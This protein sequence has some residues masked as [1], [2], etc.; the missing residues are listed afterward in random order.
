MELEIDA[1]QVLQQALAQ[2]KPGEDIDEAILRACKALYP[3][4][5][6]QA[7]TAVSRMVGAMAQQQGL[8]KDEAIQQLANSPGAASITMHT[9]TV[10]TT[11]SGSGSGPASFADLPP[12][13]QAKLREAG[14]A[15]GGRVVVERKVARS[16]PDISAPEASSSFTWREPLS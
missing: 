16:P 1:K 9:S 7:F 11:T 14:A 10:S 12:E 5:H 13:I 15:G 2:A 6:T 8:A 3:D 4:Q